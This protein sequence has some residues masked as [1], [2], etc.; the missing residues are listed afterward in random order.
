MDEFPNFEKVL[1]ERV[2][3]KNEEIMIKLRAD[4]KAR[5][6]R[7]QEEQERKRLFEIEKKQFRKLNFEN[8]IQSCTEYAVSNQ[9]KAMTCSGFYQR[10]K[11]YKGVDFGKFFT[12]EDV[13]KILDGLVKNGLLNHPSD[14]T[15]IS[16][17]GT[18]SYVPRRLPDNE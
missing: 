11:Y 18:Y 13:K 12:Q 9:I 1:A 14:P 5:E 10:V 4:K 17:Y 16:S 8:F 7:Q 2:E 6:R 15:V 3:I